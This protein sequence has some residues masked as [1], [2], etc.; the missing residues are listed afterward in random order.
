[1]STLTKI[2]HFTF[3]P[4]SHK[5]VYRYIAS[6]FSTK[7]LSSFASARPF[8]KIESCR[9][10]LSSC[11]TC[12][13]QQ[14]HFDPNPL[15]DL[16]SDSIQRHGFFL[17]SMGTIPDSAKTNQ[18]EVSKSGTMHSCIFVRLMFQVQKYK[19]HFCTFQSCCFMCMM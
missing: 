18:F 17:C 10:S 7:L 1:M 5:P 12:R 4:H 6:V 8:C 19:S 15:Q 3:Q 11:R 13:K 14:R 9:P 16:K 2:G